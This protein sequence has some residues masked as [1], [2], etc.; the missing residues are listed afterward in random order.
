MMKTAWLAT[1]VLLGATGWARAQEGAPSAP[2]PQVARDVWILQ[3]DNPKREYAVRLGA[4]QTVTLQEFDMRKEGNVQRVVEMTIETAGGN[5]ARFFWEDKPE[6]MV[7][8]SGDLEE[9]RREVEAAM[10]EVT[11]AERTDNKPSRVQ[12]DYPVTTHSGWAEFK[13][14]TENDVKNLHQQLMQMW[15]GQKR[16]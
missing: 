6:P 3:M 7:K 12:K 2:T 10:K 5:Q 16:K 1:F 4:L 13:L 15:T 8:L 9:K 14:C 11:G